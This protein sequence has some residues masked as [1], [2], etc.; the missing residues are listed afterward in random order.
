VVELE[1]LLVDLVVE[2]L[3]VLENLMKF[4]SLDP[5]QQAL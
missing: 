1:E 3:E 4:R 5:I 2:E